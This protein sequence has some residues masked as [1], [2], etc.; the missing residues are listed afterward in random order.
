M[1]LRISEMEDDKGEKNS[2]K[3]LEGYGYTASLQN[4]VLSQRKQRRLI[5]IVWDTWTSQVTL[6][7]KA[8]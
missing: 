4:G 7:S 5:T 1:F 6:T 3:L 8:V 2:I